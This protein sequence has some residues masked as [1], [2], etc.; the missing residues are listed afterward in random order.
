MQLGP[1][2]ANEELLEGFTVALTTSEI[3][4]VKH[5]LDFHH[6]RLGFETRESS[7]SLPLQ[8]E[9]NVKYLKTFG[10]STA[11]V[12]ALISPADF[13]DLHMYRR[14]TNIPLFCLS[15]CKGVLFPVNILEP[16]AQG[17]L[18]T[19]QWEISTPPCA[20]SDPWKVLKSTHQFL[21]TDQ[22]RNFRKISKSEATSFQLDHFEFGQVR[23]P[24]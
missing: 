7:S 22:E 17:I 10:F 16:E 1:D 24:A 23:L 14:I 18:C 9:K 21:S 12:T 15:S 5:E 2:K 19:S 11:I 6:I 4:A 8:Q 3:F 20:L 13:L